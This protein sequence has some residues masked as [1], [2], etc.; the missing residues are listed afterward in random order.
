MHSLLA[1]QHPQVARPASSF[2]TP[3]PPSVCAPWVSRPCRLR[4]RLPPAACARGPVPLLP[5]ASLHAYSPSAHAPRARTPRL[6]VARACPVL[7]A[8]VPRAQRRAPC[9]RP[10]ASR[11]PA[12]CSMGS[13]PFQV[14][15]LQFFF[16][17]YIFFHLILDI[18]SKIPS[19]PLVLTFIN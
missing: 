11:V 15:H 3:V 1:Q 10:R 5:R 14:L 9:L 2:R 6:L 16:S 4:A 13:S 12:L 8:C 17:L 19:K 7:S 18:L